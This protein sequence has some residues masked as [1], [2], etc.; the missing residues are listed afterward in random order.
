LG[1]APVADVGPERRLTRRWI[2]GLTA[3]VLVLA[4]AGFLLGR[5]RERV[6]QRETAAAVGGP[7]SL[8]FPTD[9]WEPSEA[10]PELPG[11]GL[12]DPISLVSRAGDGTGALVAGMADG[13]EGPLLLPARFVG[14]LGAAPRSETVRLGS[15]RALRYRDVQDPSLSGRLNLY[16]VP[17][18]AG[19]AT[20]ACVGEGAVLASCEGIASTLG[21]RG[22]RPLAPAPNAR[23]SEALD[24]A[25]ARLQRLRERERRVLLLARTPEAQAAAA[26]R[27][28]AAYGMARQTIGEAEP[29]PVEQPGHRVLVPALGE[30]RLAYRSLAGGARTSR[31]PV[32]ARAAARVRRAERAVDRAARALTGLA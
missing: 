6:E 26:E 18:T 9:E 29:G 13:A 19:T 3:A 7:L 10:V 2:A 17:T 15:L 24:L 20:V 32:Y 30:A 8:A 11:L 22:A 5:S 4:L 16:V 31:R 28:A 12:A 27:L 25:L 1:R 14:E 21:L 23:Y